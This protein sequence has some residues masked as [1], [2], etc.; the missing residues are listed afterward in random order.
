[1]NPNNSIIS[2]T[3]LDVSGQDDVVIHSL[4]FIMHTFQV[5]PNGGDFRK[6]F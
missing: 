4:T 5:S 1:M 2:E 6:F 3:Y